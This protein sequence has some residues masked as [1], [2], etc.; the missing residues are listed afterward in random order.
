MSN[1]CELFSIFP[2]PVVKFR[3]PENLMRHVESLKDRTNQ[4]AVRSG[5]NIVS[6]D[7]YIL[8]NME[9]EDI[10]AWFVS[11]STEFLRTVQAIDSES[12]ITQSWINKNSTGNSCHVHSHQ[13]SIISGV[14]YMDCPN[15][16]PGLSFHKPEIGGMFTWTMEPQHFVGIEQDYTYVSR[17]YNMEVSSGELI[18]FPSW[19]IHSV[20]V[21]NAVQDRWSL[22]FNTMIPM[23][24]G[25]RNRS[26]EFIYPKT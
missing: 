22:A 3:V 17:T 19:L 25:V 8:D 6:E 13:N 21:N 10:R 7:K 23:K 18:L 16:A 11:R 4:N 14:F 15:G 20:P 9:Y 2:T 26:N 1:D 5:R 12:I 24:I